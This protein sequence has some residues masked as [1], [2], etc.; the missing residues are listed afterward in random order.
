[1]YAAGDASDFPIKH[2]GL[3]SQQADAAAEAIAALAGADV[4]AAAVRAR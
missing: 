2:G 1:M 3:A 4:R